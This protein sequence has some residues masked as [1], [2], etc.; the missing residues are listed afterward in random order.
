MSLLA[1]Y[2]NDH[3]AGATAGR[4]LARRIAS[5]NRGSDLY[6]PPSQQLAEEVDE[7]RETLLEIMRALGVGVD[8]V[9]VAGGWTVE[10]LGRLKPN[11][12]LLSYSPLSRLVELEAMTLGVRGKL[13]MWDALLE[14]VADDERLAGVDLGRLAERAAAQL[15]T[16]EP[17]RLAAAGEALED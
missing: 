9:K 11:G 1:T 8:H 13:A 10:K 17:L 4:E 5:N 14:V 15:E 7:D 3:L 6:G 12:R 16:L 2:L